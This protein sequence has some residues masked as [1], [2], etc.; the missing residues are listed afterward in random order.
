VEVS[1]PDKPIFEA[2]GHTKSD[3]VGHYR[4]VGGR[5]I[6]FVAG[7]PLTLQRFPNGI[8]A[9]GFMQ[10]NAPGHFPDSI[11]RFEVPK[12]DGG[13]TTYPVVDR[14]E[15]LAYLANQ[16][17]VTFHM[18]TSTA[19]RPDRP[20][21]L[22]LD[23][24]PDSGDLDGVRAATRAIHDLLDEFD[25]SGFPLA[26]G[27]SGFHV[28]AALDGTARTGEVSTT[29]RALAGIAAHRHPELLTVEFLKKKRRG[30]VFVDWLRNGPTA[31]VVA[32]FSLRPRPH[33]PVAVPVRWGEIDEVTP[34][35]WTL[36]DLGDRLDVDPERTPQR[37]PIGRIAEVA[38]EAGVDLEAPFDRFGRQ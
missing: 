18:W 3:L 34:D 12:Q 16:G 5:M 17:T 2:V 13:T 38:A 8:E 33:A 31:T 36:D 29:A 4:R 32:P 26:T 6:E 23:L 15:D 37:L 1:N 14:A 25:V 24:D 19:H 9:G 21:W 35:H 22:I 27:S 28:W 7:R 20:D 10:K 30:R 11:R